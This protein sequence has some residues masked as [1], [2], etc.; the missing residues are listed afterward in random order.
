MAT[1]AAMRME[2]SG[3]C[4]EHNWREPCPDCSVAAPRDTIEAPLEWDV[5]HQTAFHGPAEHRARVARESAEYRAG[6][7]RLPTTRK[8]WM[9]RFSPIQTRSGKAGYWATLPD[10]AL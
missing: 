6:A 8:E 5:W 10:D 1:V 3:F 2:Q 9:E 4:V 7:V